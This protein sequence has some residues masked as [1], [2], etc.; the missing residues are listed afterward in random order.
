M[1]GVVPNSFGVRVKEFNQN[2]VPA[3]SPQGGQ[4]ASKEEASGPRPTDAD[5]DFDTVWKPYLDRGRAWNNKL[6]LAISMG[7]IT[8]EEATKLGWSHPED[9]SIKYEALPPVLYHVSTAYNDILQQGLKTRKEIGYVNRGLG[10]GSS[11]TV[12]FT[13]DLATARAIRA[14]ILEAR[15]VLTGDITPAQLVRQALAQP[16]GKD[17]KSAASLLMQFYGAKEGW[18]KGDPLPEGLDRLVRG[19]IREQPGYSND[20]QLKQLAA[21]ARMMGMVP[22]S[23]LPSGITVTRWHQGRDE[24]FAAEIERP[25][26]SDEKQSDAFELYKRYST[27]REYAGGRLD[28]LFFTTD[29]KALAAVKVK[30]IKIMKFRPTRGARGYRVSSLGEW[31]VNTGKTV[32]YD[33]LAESR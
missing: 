12:S 24:R 20:P 11:D 18:K 14:G 15:R 13:A 7:K 22:E 26:T 8:Q 5:A 2:H 29:E 21:S 25:R 27:A 17:G 31:R 30:D 4:F 28:P 1:I 33:G 3:G 32:K 16:V 10:G 23:Q 19:V 9:S 6:T